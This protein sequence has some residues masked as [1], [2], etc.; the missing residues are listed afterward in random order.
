[1]AILNWP[2]CSASG[3]KIWVREQLF[4]DPD[5]WIIQAWCQVILGR[6]QQQLREYD[7]A[8]IAYRKAVEL[9]PSSSKAHFGLGFGLST[10]GQFEESEGSTHCIHLSLGSLTSGVLAVS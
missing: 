5:Y 3:W 8:V 1:L 7:S 2:N 10:T 4:S 9:C 6:A